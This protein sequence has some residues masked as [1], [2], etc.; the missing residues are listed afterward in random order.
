MQANRFETPVALFVFR[1]P[2]TTQK[3]F[4]A[5]SN[6]RPSRLLLI[7][8]GPRPDKIGEAEACRQVR[9]IVSHVD[10]PCEV[11]TNFADHNLG[12]QERMISGFNWVFSLVEEAILF[13]DDCL[14][15]PSFFPFCQE[16]LERYRGD[17]RIGYISGCNQ[18]EKDTTTSAS[19]YYSRIGSCWGWATW[20]SQW[21]RYD[22]HLD[23][24]PA[25]RKDNTLAEVFDEP[26]TVAYWTKIF[27]MMHENRLPTAWDYQ[28]MFT[29]LK[30]NSVAAVSSVNAICNI[31]YGP[32]ATHATEP[33]PRNMRLAKQ[34]QFPLKHPSS[35]IPSRTMDRSLQKL[36]TATLTF[37]VKR[38]LRQFS[39]RAFSRS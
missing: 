27:D 39:R 21:Q 36:L 26:K 31:G 25:M 35:F 13:E 9:D 28:W 20:R 19:Y 14:P 29:C 4:E 32:G 17:S 5:I 23:D 1:R 6:A 3:V 34:V 15:D 12:C 8:D 7:A 22:R 37:R 18:A 16:L 2:D 24:W 33:D 11:S 30:N 10:W 38:K